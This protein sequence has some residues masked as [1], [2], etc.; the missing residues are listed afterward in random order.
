MMKNG[1][2]RRVGQTRDAQSPV[3]DWGSGSPLERKQME[4]TGLEKTMTQ[5]RRIRIALHTIADLSDQDQRHICQDVL[6][7]V[8]ES[9]A[10]IVKDNTSDVDALLVLVMH[11]NSA[12]QIL[13]AAD[14]VDCPCIIWAVRG[15][16]A[17]P[18]SSLAIGK[19]EEEQKPVKLVYGQPAEEDAVEEFE[20]A[21]RSV[22]ALRQLA[23][24]KIGNIGG[25][26]PN[27][28]ACAY[29][30]EGIRSRL[31]TEIIEIS[32]DTVREKEVPED[33]VK[34]FIERTGA[35]H[36]VDA[37]LA[38]KCQAGIRLH[39]A[40]KQIARQHDLDAFAV[41]C[42]SRFPKE[43]GTNPCFGFVEDDYIMAC[44]GDVL[45]AVNQILVRA[46]TG[47]YPYAGDVY[48]LDKQSVLTLKHCGAPMSLGTDEEGAVIQESEEA[49]KQGFPTLVCR[50]QMKRG[51]VT[52]L[53][54]YGGACEYMHMASGEV[55]G[56]E[57]LKEMTVKVKIRGSRKHFIENCKGNHYVVV[58]GDIAEEIRLLCK[59]KSIALVDC[60][61]S[62]PDHAWDK[63]SFGRG[64]AE[65]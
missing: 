36:T 2:N 14:G 58:P 43:L 64:G 62:E 5:G 26:Y 38:G 34:A 53:R 6:R 7:R 61:D 23:R 16:W 57:N 59:W 3:L 35:L 63:S 48:D 60:C 4:D 19:L 1:H 50:P 41:E 28:V 33:D 8:H 47:I 55:I 9:G 21:L 49:E 30:K 17:W 13:A 15:R 18:S 52:L 65:T 42:W 54:L 40:L 39:L 46:I 51:P 32:F 45:L 56:T 37:D 10:E 24:S 27:L 20:M 31:G 22:F 11:G 29:D 12:R 44:E 25:L